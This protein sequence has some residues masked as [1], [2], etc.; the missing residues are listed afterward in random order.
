MYRHY[1]YVKY[2]HFLYSQLTYYPLIT[3]YKKCL[4]F[5]YCY[6]IWSSF[7]FHVE[8]TPVHCILYDFSVWC[9]NIVSTI[10]H[11]WHKVCHLGIVSTW[12]IYLL[13]MYLNIWCK[14]SFSVCLYISYILIMY[15][16]CCKESLYNVIPT[17]W[18]MLQYNITKGYQTAPGNLVNL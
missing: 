17:V 7:L 2:K 1:F 9:I 5:T 10:S 11:T 14:D 15:R 8:I 13:Y 6:R 4:Y 3:R 16:N 18:E 12:N